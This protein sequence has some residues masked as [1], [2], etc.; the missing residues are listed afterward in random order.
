MSE[1]ATGSAG[2]RSPGNPLS[3]VGAH[4]SFLHVGDVVS[5]FAEGT[6]SGF[7]CTLGLVDDRCVVKPKAGDLNAPP[8]K[9]RDCLFRM[10]PMNRYSAQKQFW[11]SAKSSTTASTADAVLLKKLHVS[12]NV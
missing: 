2:I 6:V 7:L 10:C 8:K 9:F 4:S 3:G 11:K 12:C 1:S 5:L